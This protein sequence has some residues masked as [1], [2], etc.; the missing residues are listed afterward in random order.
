MLPSKT[1]TLA[2]YVEPFAEKYADIAYQP[3]VD[4]IILRLEMA[5]AILQ[6]KV[7]N[8]ST[9]VRKEELTIL[10]DRVSVLMEQRKG[11]L[12]GGGATAG[13]TRRSLSEFQPIAG[14]TK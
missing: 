9:A 6:D 10:N 8:D 12:V 14:H 11:E 1:A 3:L 13:N 5:V 4:D 2:Y 7:L